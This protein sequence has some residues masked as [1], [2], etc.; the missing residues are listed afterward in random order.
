MVDREWDTGYKDDRAAENSLNARLNPGG[1]DD[2]EQEGASTQGEI[3]GA[4][5]TEQQKEPQRKVK[6][7]GQG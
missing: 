4:G 6:S 2:R 7:R 5:M 3:P 1:K